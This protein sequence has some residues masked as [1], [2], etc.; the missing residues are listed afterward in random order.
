MYYGMLTLSV[1]LF[2][3]MFFFNDRY[4]AENGNGMESTFIFSFFTS[5]AGLVFLLFFNG[6]SFSL[7]PFTLMMAFF[8]AVNNILFMVFSLKA[9]NSV[10]L[11]LF[12]LFT[13]LGG[14]MLPFAAGIMFFGEPLTFAVIV[15]VIL[16]IA[17]LLLT[18]K[19]GDGKKSFL[20]YC[21]VFVMNGMSGVLSKIY[22]N[23]DLPKTNEALYSIWMT[24]ITIVISGI[25]LIIL[26]RNLKKQSMSSVISMIGYGA[27]NKV[28]N[29][30][31][32]LA[33]AVLPASVQY[34]FVTGGTV[35]VSTI[36]AAL[37]KQKPTKR[38]I[39]AVAVSFIGIMALVIL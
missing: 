37:A 16:N 8:A 22:Q 29:Y 13:M 12:S 9:L 20:I 34:P 15:C 7:T 21:G 17:A 31:L 25:A 32:L 33:L 2:G 26:R 6:L 19:K 35:I 1:I 11:S 23:S 5:A 28:G 30:L 39:A 14:M 10:N 38:E 3:L 36:I 4:Q 27:F 24:L 18:V